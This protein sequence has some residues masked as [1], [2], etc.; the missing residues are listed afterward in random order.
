MYAAK[1]AKLYGNLSLADENGVVLEIVEDATTYGKDDVEKCLVGKVLSRKRVNREAFKGL[2]ERRARWLAEQISETVEILF[3][4][5]ECWGKYMRVKV[6]LDI[7]KPLKRW[8]RLK[9]GKTEEVTMV[10]LRYKRLPD[11][12]YACGRIGHGMKECLDEEA[13]SVAIEGSTTKFGSWLRAS[14]SEKSSTRLNTQVLV[15]SSRRIHSTKNSRELEG[16]D[17][18]NQKSG[19]HS[20]PVVDSGR[21][22]SPPSF[23][24]GRNFKFEPFWLKQADYH[25][26][27]AEAWN[28]NKVFNPSTNLLSKLKGCASS[29]NGWSKSR[30]GNSHKQIEDKN[31]EIERLYGLFG[32]PGIMTSIR[33]LE[34]MVEGLIERFMDYSWQDLEQ[35]YGLY[36]AQC[37]QKW[38]NNQDFQLDYN[39]VGTILD[40]EK[41]VNLISKYLQKNEE[42]MLT[43]PGAS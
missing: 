9:L 25:S 11:F 14:S 40:E 12:C 18:V 17:S 43:Q 38:G 29:L 15:S 42:T 35:G 20:S 33:A 28:K 26:T 5:S 19:S 6:R 31:R 21:I 13:K 24:R 3:E 10:G 16:G 37:S 22:V 8:L 27:V 30:F 4:S 2:I 34:R 36:D 23:G 41:L 32:K 39:E 1:I 7:S